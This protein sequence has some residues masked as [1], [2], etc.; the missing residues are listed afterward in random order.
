MDELNPVTKWIERARTGDDEAVG[1]LWQL[2]FAR[3]TRLAR[4]RMALMSRGVYDEEDAALSAMH[5]FFRGVKA[6]R[7][8]QLKDRHNMWRLLAVITARKVNRQR[9]VNGAAKRG[10]TE[11]SGSVTVG[12][13][14][15]I[16]DVI[17][18]EP[19]PDF[20]AEML[21]DL[22]ARINLLPDDTLRRI[23]LLT[24]DGLTQVEIAKSMNCTVRTIHRKLEAIRAVWEDADPEL[25]QPD[26]RFAEEISM[27]K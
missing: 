7:F 5:S 19:T 1:E 25:A 3:L 10:G 18:H 11:G 9:Q 21:D 13:S 20:V 26:V 4:G 6:E 15:E 17:D 16:L 14:S 23:A 27:T 8:P 2:Y 24:M 22:Q 12:G